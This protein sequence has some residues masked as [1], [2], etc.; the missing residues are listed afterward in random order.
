MRRGAS[1]EEGGGR[2]RLRPAGWERG[3][4]TVFLALMLTCFFSA[5]FAYLE[6]ARVK[7]LA[8][9]SEISTMQSRD[10]VL[11]SYHREL[12]DQYHL[13]F[14]YAPDGDIPGLS[15]LGSLQQAA[16]E[17][18]RANSILHSGNYYVL[19]V[20]L[21]EVTTTGFQLVT[22]SGGAAFRSQAAEMMKL[23][24]AEN[25][26]DDLLTWITGSDIENVDETAEDTDDLETEALDALE[27]LE[28][29]EAAAKES[30]SEDVSSGTDAGAASGA[31]ASAGIKIQENPLTWVRKIKNNG[32]LAFVTTEQNISD[33][34][35]DTGECI[36]KRSLSAGNTLVEADSG[37]LDDLVW[38]YLYLDE[39]FYDFTESPEDH[40]LDYELE[41]MIAGKAND[42]ANLK[43]VVRRLLATR[44]AANMVFLETNAAKR[45]EAAAVALLLSSVVA[46]PELQPLVQQGV[47]AAWAYAESIS[48]VRI[49]LEGGKVRLV[50]TEDQW[51]TDIKALSSTVMSTDG[52]QQTDGLTYANYLQLL[53]R[54]VSKEKLT[55]RAMDMIE[56]NLD[57]KMDQMLCYAEC[58]YVYESAP[59]FWNFVTLGSNSLG[60]YHFK[61]ETTIS[62]LKLSG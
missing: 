57:V 32:I 54:T 36:A 18:N 10:T 12:W 31:D 49:L 16:V 2:G 23:T 7:G 39:Y 34:A 46:M 20:H 9:N 48:D 24:M 21:T 22:D 4:I 1:R 26:V 15:A 38:F 5:V 43:A 33:K 56:K 62:F 6:I 59:L 29:A 19:P 58:S 13:M 61:D 14:W 51:H 42:K 50:K 27:A 40:A 28:S 41:Y 3:S 60:A 11:A 25:A 44:E 8:A 47:M 53:M 30:G 35:I 17:G 55:Q 45:E 52:K 37:V